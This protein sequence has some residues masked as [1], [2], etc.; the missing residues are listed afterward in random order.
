MSIGIQL[1]ELHD[2][3][4]YVKSLSES[5]KE[6]I[7]NLI[8]RNNELLEGDVIELIKITLKNNR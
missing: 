6:E 7:A 5:D 4:D 2:R 1:G 3:L 8:R